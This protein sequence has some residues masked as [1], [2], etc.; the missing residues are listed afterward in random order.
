MDPKW[1]VNNGKT[2][3]TKITFNHTNKTI[4]EWTN[5]QISKFLKISSKSL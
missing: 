4:V 3:A 1:R 5:E 2:P